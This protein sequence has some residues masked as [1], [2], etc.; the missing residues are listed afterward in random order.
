[1]QLL[2]LLIH[3]RASLIL[4]E[5][6]FFL[7]GL[8]VFLRYLDFDFEFDLDFDFDLDFFDWFFF[9]GMVGVQFGSLMKVSR[10]LRSCYLYSSSRSRSGASVGKVSMVTSGVICGATL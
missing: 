2:L 3:L 8:F 6:F 9:C 1:M 5:T 7:E 4:G 10:D